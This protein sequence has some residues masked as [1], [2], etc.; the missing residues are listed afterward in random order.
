MR[1][2]GDLGDDPVAPRRPIAS[3]LVKVPRLLD[4]VADMRLAG[5]IGLGQPPD[6]AIGGIVQFEPAIA[7]EYGDAL[8]QVVERFAL[9]RDQ[10]VV[11]TFQRQPIGDVLVDEDQA[12]QRM[13]RHRQAEGAAVGQVHQLAHGL[14]QRGEHAQL[15]ALEGAEIGIFRHP[16]A[17]AQPLQQF[18]E[19]RFAGEPILFEPPQPGEGR[20]E[21]TEPLVRTIDRDGSVD[22]FKHLAMRIDVPRQIA[23]GAFEIGAVDREADRA[24]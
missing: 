11:R 6:R 24:A 2:C 1:L 15:L 13:R 16:A 4:D 14:D 5:E 23:F 17:F 19:R 10:R 9:H 22:A 12:A 20:I 7:A 21:E 8:E 18:V 3:V